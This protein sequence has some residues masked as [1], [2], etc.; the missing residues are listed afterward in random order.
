VIS[1]KGSSVPR[2]RHE[3]LFHSTVKQAT[4]IFHISQYNRAFQIL[5]TNNNISKQDNISKPPSQP[6]NRQNE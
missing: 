1:D 2:L 5:P 4:D 6:G 3:F